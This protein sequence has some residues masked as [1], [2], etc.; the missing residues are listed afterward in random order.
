MELPECHRRGRI[1]R[2]ILVVVDRLTKRRIYEPLESLSTSKFIEVMNRRVFPT[3]GYP[4]TIVN[5][6]GGQMTSTLWKRLCKRHGIKVKFSSAHHPKTDG[7]TENANK[8]MKNYLQA[9]ISYTQDDWVDHLPMAEFSANNHINESTGMIPFFADNGF[10]PRTGVEPP[11]AY[12]Q[13]SRKAK[14]L[15]ADKIVKQEEET[16]SF[17][18]EQLLWSQQEQA[19]WTN[20]NRQPHPEYRVGDIV[21]VDA[22]HF[23]SK[24]DSKSLSMKNAGPWKIIRNIGNKAYELDMPQQMKDSGLTPVFHPWKLHLAPKNPFPGQ[25]L[26]PGPPVL[27]S[28]GDE[29]Y[30]E[31]KV[32]KVVDSRKTKKYG[33][34]YK[35]TYIGN[36]DE[37]NSNPTWQPYSDFENSKEKIREFHRTHPKKPRP[38]SDLVI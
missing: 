35:A 6:R 33:V 36:W 25:A 9:Y 5:D 31:W 21:Y 12:Q 8:V 22:R 34:Q 18:Q 10:H 29:T 7:Q 1:F 38:P 11:Q 3:H 30:E 26:E 19:H 2:H 13:A 14:L 28:S 4:L 17:L 23:A 37:W 20:Q 15:T 16:R 24:R 27:V 32:L